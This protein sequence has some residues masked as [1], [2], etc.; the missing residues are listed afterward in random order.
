MTGACSIFILLLSLAG[1]VSHSAPHCSGIWE[2]HGVTVQ[3]RGPTISIVSETRFDQRSVVVFRSRV[4][5]V[6]RLAGATLV[7]RSS[8][9]L[10]T[11][12]LEKGVESHMECAPSGA[13]TTWSSFPDV[14]ALQGTNGIDLHVRPRP[15]DTCST[16]SYW[17]LSLPTM[18]TENRFENDWVHLSQRPPGPPKPL[19]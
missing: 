18:R 11:G 13:D 2:G 4:E 5:P 15:D 16:Y 1:P 10:G 9:T 14:P 12:A 7:N 3:W 19:Y 6:L 8:R 17:A